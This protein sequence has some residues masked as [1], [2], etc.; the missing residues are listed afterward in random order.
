MT[1]FLID[2]DSDSLRE[3]LD[4][5]L[6]I[7]GANIAFE[8]KNIDNKAK[9]SNLIILKQKLEDNNIINFKVIC[10]RSLHYQ[11]DDPQ[12]YD[13]L[14]KKDNRF[15]ESPGG[16]QADPFILQYAYDING[17]IVSND[18]FKDFSPLFGKEW[19]QSRR[20]SFRIIEEQI[21]F[22]KLIPTIN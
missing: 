10:D 7:D 8:A 2:F 17:W 9:F 20:I 11:I 16:S 4:S 12:I 13:D 14:I 18:N 22:D 21:Y 6:I 1:L 19:I 3:F 5:P 15:I